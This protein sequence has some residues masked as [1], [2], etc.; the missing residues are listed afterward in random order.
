MDAKSAL[1]SKNRDVFA[2]LR[3]G[4]TVLGRSVIS[5]G[6]YWKAIAVILV[7]LVFAFFAPPLAYFFSLIAVLMFVYCYIQ[8]TILSLIVTNQRVFIRAGILK[9]DTVQ[10]RVERIESVEV[11]KTLV[12][13]ALGYGT[14]IMTGVGNQFAFVPYID[15]SAELRNVLDEVLY[16]RDKMLQASIAQTAAQAQPVE[17]QQET[18]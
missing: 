12:G 5:N 11:Q 10:M 13:Y 8:Q 7:A 3:E 17:P 14:V 18:L 2:D 4:E 9:I 1:K 6:I 16:Q 15:N